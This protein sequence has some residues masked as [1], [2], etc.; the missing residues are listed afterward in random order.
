MK[1]TIVQNRNNDFREEKKKK[2]KMKPIK[3]LRKIGEEG[4]E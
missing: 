4:E 2:A 3:I 1:F